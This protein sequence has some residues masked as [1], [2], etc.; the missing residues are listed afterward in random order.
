MTVVAGAGYVGTASR[1]AWSELLLL[2]L[3][4]LLSVLPPPREWEASRDLVQLL[5]LL[6]L[7]PSV[8]G[9]EDTGFVAPATRGV[10]SELLLRS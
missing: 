3:L 8:A 5:L 4:L 1:G 7:G 9:G 6:L 2:L 10:G